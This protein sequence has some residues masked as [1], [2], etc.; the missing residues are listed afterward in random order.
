MKKQSTYQMEQVIVLDPIPEIRFACDLEVCKGGC[1]TMAGGKGAPLLD[2]E[3]ASIDKHFPVV[4]PILPPEHLQVIRSFGKYEGETGSYT[5]MCYNNRSCVFVYYDQ[6]IARCAYEKAY[7]EGKITWRKPLSCHLFPIRVDRRSTLKIRYEQIA[8]CESALLRGKRE[9]IFLST[10][11]QDSL[12]RAFGSP[13]YTSFQNLCTLLQKDSKE[14]F[15]H[16]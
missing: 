2:N 12:T 5:T 10:F 14:P 9:N 16:D 13:W 11:L 3:L 7:L 6:S 1:C 4:E 15:T 8:E